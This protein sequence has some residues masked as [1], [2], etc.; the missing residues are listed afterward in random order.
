MT[1]EKASEIYH[2]LKHISQSGDGIEYLMKEFE[3]VEAMVRCCVEKTLVR[4]RRCGNL[5]YSDRTCWK[6]E[7]DQKK[8]I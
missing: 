5:T 8:V 4:C 1:R 3:F 2:T 7:S 6:C